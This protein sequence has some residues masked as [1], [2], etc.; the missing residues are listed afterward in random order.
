MTSLRTCRRRSRTGRSGSTTGPWTGTT[1]TTPST[2]S[3]RRTGR[4]SPKTSTLRRRARVPGAGRVHGRRQGHRH[5]RQRHDEDDVG[6]GGWPWRVRHAQ[7]QG[8][9]GDLLTAR[10]T[11]APCVPEIR[12]AVEEW[13][14]D[15]VQG[16][17]GHDEDALQLLVRDGPPAARTGSPS[18]TTTRSARRWRRSSGSTRWRRSGAIATSS[19]ASPRCPA[20]TSSS[21]TTSPG[22]PSR[23]RPAAARR[24]SW[25]SPSPGSTSTPS[26][27]ARDDYAKTFL[28]VAPNVIVFERLRSDFGGGRVFQDRPHHPAGASHL[29]GDGLLHARRSRASQLAGRALPDEHPAVLRATLGPLIPTSRRS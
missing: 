27:R 7:P 29:L 13:R 23:W 3:G 20:S 24:R 26:P 15:E 21:T 6:E 17:H 25:R 4:G 28:I 18:S 5:P 2:T 16:R 14:T 9:Q 12:K 1:R 10:V 8:E 11:T 22:T 19:S